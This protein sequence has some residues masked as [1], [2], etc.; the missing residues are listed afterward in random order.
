MDLTTNLKS[1]LDSWIDLSAHNRRRLER[2]AESIRVFRSDTAATI[3]LG[4]LVF[5]I[6]LA[7]FAPYLAP[8]DPT[9]T[10]FAEDGSAMIL[11]EPTSDNLFGTTQYGKDVFSQ[12]VFGSRISILVGLLSA[13]V[14]ATV[15]TTVGVIAGY[16]R[17]IVDTAL[18]RVVDTLYGFPATPFILVL[19]LLLGASVWNVILAMVLVLWRTMARLTRSQTL[20]LS[21]R[22]YVK[23]ARSAGASDLRIMAYH[24][25][26][27]LV[28]LIL[29]ETTFVAGRAIVLE[30]GVSFLGFG[31]TNAVSWGTML[32]S[33]FATGAIRKA[34]WWVLPPGLSIAMIVISLF[35]ISR[36]LEEVTNPELRVEENR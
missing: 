12:W 21:Q 4:V 34:W 25:V 7:L 27:N 23:A 5:Y 24:I 31:T 1:T 10:M 30:A 28:P 3:A 13:V 2:Y 19:A 26:P 16:Y 15:G 14:V 9:A 18:M 6:L 8:H 22:P 33:S 29:I 32:Q 36:G 20:S 11:E 35:Y 17:G